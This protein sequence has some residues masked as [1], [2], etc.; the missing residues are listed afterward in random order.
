[1]LGEMYWQARIKLYESFVCDEPECDGGVTCSP[2]NI[3]C[4]NCRSAGA[5]VFEFEREGGRCFDCVLEELRLIEL[6]HRDSRN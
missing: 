6:V 2:V 1:M 3:A 4:V 5:H